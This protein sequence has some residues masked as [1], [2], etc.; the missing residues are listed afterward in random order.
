MKLNFEEIIRSLNAK[1]HTISY[2]NER[3][4]KLIKDS[5]KKLEGNKAFS[6]LI[7][8][9]KVSIDLIKQYMKGEYTSLSKGNLTLIIIGF[10]YLVNPI[11]I[12]PDFILGT[13][14]L[15]DAAVFAY[16]LKMIHHEIEAFKEWKI[17]QVIEEDFEDV[18]DLD[19]DDVT[20]ISDE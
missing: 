18:I 9:V 12:I 2:D 11:D 17:T 7:D 16:L 8:D 5:K 4:N 13:G 14:F 6:E 1:A 19:D 3:L 15:D 20:D 10:L